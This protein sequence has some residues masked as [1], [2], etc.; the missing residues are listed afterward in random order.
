MRS[1][2]QG[3]TS[4]KRQFVSKIDET[5]VLAESFQLFKIPSWYLCKLSLLVIPIK[6]SLL[7]QNWFNFLFFQCG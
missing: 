4:V 6:L 3:K 1:W 5:E 7:A 2:Y